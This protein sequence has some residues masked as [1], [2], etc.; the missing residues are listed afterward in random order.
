MPTPKVNSWLG[1][2]IF[3]VNRCYGNTTYVHPINFL[4][5]GMRDVHDTNNKAID[6]FFGAQ[7]QSEFEWVQIEDLACRI[8]LEMKNAHAR[9]AEFQ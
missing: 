6:Y 4:A 8:W 3:T 1:W 2:R 7:C 5:P 9:N